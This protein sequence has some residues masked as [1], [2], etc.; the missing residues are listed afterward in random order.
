ME[1]AYFTVIPTE[2]KDKFSVERLPPMQVYVS[3]TLA[4]ERA[5]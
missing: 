1:N 3:L 2:E 5:K 4:S